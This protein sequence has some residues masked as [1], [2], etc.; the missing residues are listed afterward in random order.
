MKK[1]DA[2]SNME[3]VSSKEFKD[4]IRFAVE[5]TQRNVDAGDTIMGKSF[6]GTVVA[7]DSK[8]GVVRAF[9]VRDYGGRSEGLNAL[10]RTA[11]HVSN[12]EEHSILTIIDA[13]EFTPNCHSGYSSQR[14][15]FEKV[16]LENRFMKVYIN[17]LTGGRN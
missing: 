11:S 6:F 7:Y 12:L 9:A 14:N 17:I 1:F 2:A 4:S 13:E 8:V 16:L 10:G 3:I 15:E 5:E